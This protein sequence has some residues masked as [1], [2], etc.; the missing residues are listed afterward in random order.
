MGDMTGHITRHHAPAGVVEAPGY[1]NVVG[2]EG[3]LVVVAGQVSRDADGQLV[4]KGDFTAQARQVFDNIRLCLAAEGATFTDV[5]KLNY[6]LAD[7]ADIVSL[8]EVRIE[9]MDDDDRP[10]STAVQVAA[11]FD[12]AFL[13]E[14]EAWAV[15]PSRGAAA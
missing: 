11:L 14:V 13:L 15:V 12:P 5:V 7:M 9:N 10:A 4:G 2:A 6:Y 8:R 1:C 3:R